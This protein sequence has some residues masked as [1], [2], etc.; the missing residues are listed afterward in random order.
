MEIA[1][2][3]WRQGLR[4]IIRLPR[5]FV[6]GFIVAMIWEWI[7]QRYGFS[8]WQ[9]L[10]AS[11]H[12]PLSILFHQV[13]LA[14]ILASI[15]IAVHRFVILGEVLDRPIWKLPATYRIFVIWL[16][17]CGISSTLLSEVVD[18][19]SPDY[20]VAGML[21]VFVADVLLAIVSV[22]LMLIFP[23]IA[24]ESPYAGWRNAWRDSRG[25]AWRLFGIVL[26]AALPLLI[27]QVILAVMAI[28]STNSPT[29]DTKWLGPVELFAGTAALLLVS[30]IGAVIASR[31]FQLYGN[32][33]TRPPQASGSAAV[34]S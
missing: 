16:L 33:L 14:L 19:L 1:I 25:H 34:P 18:V 22:R 17:L 32:A 24:V 20:L 6:S 29:I 23:A 3:G 31:L 26:L 8:P 5:L 7:A 12:L 9:G 10:R 21:F 13:V 27:P 15:V 30:S 28:R 2:D 11:K 4:A